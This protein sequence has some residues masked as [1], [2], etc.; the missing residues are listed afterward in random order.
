MDQQGGGQ[1]LG[2]DP[3]DPSL[4]SPDAQLAGF[5]PNMVGAASNFVDRA[6][7]VLLDQAITGGNGTLSITVAYL[8]V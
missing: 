2:A 6:L 4:S 1:L 5:Y 7:V 3:V 8:V